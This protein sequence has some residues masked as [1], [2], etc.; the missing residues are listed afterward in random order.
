MGAQ[1]QLDGNEFADL[2]RAGHLRLKANVDQVNALNIF[3]VPDGDTGTNMELSLAAGV[4]RLNAEQTWTIN[5]A[6]QTLASGLLMG[7]RGN[8]GVILSQL[9]R[10]FLRVTGRNDSLDVPAM[11]LAFQEGVNIAY[12]AVAKPVEGTILTVAREA[13]TVGMKE[14]KHGETFLEWM[15]KV[16]SAAQKALLRTPEQ[17]PVLKQANVVDSGGQGYVYILEGFL[18]W[19]GG[20][21]HIE[22]PSTAVNEGAMDKRLFAAAHI[23]HEGEYGYCTEV[24]V[25]VGPSTAT[26]AAE[27]TLRQQL[28][29]YGDS[30]LVVGAENL[31]KVHVHTLHPGRVLEDALA[32]GEITHVKIENMTLQHEDIQ[33]RAG[34]A[35]A[36]TPGRSLARQTEQRNVAIVAVVSGA[37]LR[38]VFEDLSV[39]VI[40]EGGQTMNPSTEDILAAVESTEA[41]HVIVLPNNKNIVMAAEQARN[42]LGDKVAVV[43]TANIA[44]G[45]AAMMSVRSQDTF[46]DTVG[47]MTEAAV[48]VQSGQVVRAVRDSTFQGREICSGQF[49]GFVNQDLV[50]V[51]DDRN[52]VVLVLLDRLDAANAEL[53]TV[54][55]GRDVTPADVT[56]LADIIRGRYPVTVEIKD[57]GQP[58][59]DYIFTVE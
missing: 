49:L 14:A 58:V 1:T 19:F 2:I 40:V 20:Q 5:K 23:H 16:Y 34:T 46:A 21:V 30:L 6:A 39:D 32:F 53:M 44:Q 24:M 17:L 27:Q 22:P 13:A 9:V 7:A 18:Q 8:S 48:Q 38:R 54:F 57:G 36:G 26:E 55:H 50:V 41:E 42:V 4:A 56:A 35:S 59:F 31:V 47:R 45:I 12:R 43:P 37:G 29:D 15:Q 51:E 52:Q 10:G 33:A 11:A 25:R 3:P 28:S